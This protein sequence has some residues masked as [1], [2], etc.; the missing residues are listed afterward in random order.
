MSKLLRLTAFF[1]LV[2]AGSALNAQGNCSDE[3]LD[4]IGANNEFVQGVAADCGQSCLFAANPEACFEACMSNQV[5]LTANCIDCFTQQVDCATSSCFF[6]CVFGSEADCAACIEANCL[7][8]FQECAGI[9]DLDN[10]GFTNLTDCDD[11]NPNVYPGAPGTG[12]NIDNNCNGVLDPDEIGAPDCVGDFNNDLAV[13][14]AD[15]LIFLADFGC[16]GICVADL[17]GD[18]LTG[19]S[20]LL[21][22]LAVF[23]T[24]CN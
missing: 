3:D 12:E 5:P 6:P 16:S 20:D 11:N 9:V 17:D 23:G 22:F 2:L 19:S 10:D 4:Y 7:V 21:I 1:V 13:G 14:T 24:D 18:L 8:A 15:L